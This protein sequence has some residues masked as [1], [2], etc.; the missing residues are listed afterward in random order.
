VVWVIRASINYIEGIE[1]LGTRDGVN[2]AFTTPDAFRDDDLATI[3]VF[4]NGRRL[5]KSPDAD[6]RNGDFLTS[7]SVPGGGYD[8]ITINFAPV[9]TSELRADYVLG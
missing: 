6:P 2:R 5:V 9:S 3:R 8:T 7:E 1:L 4:H